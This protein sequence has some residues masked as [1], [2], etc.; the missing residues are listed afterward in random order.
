MKLRGALWALGGLLGFSS[1]C[2]AAHPV[3][4]HER[5]EREV[6]PMHG[7]LGSFHDAF[8]PVYHM[9]KGDERDA[10][11]CSNAPTFAD[12]AEHV[13]ADPRSGKDPAFDAAARSLA[14]RV[15]ELGAACSAHDDIAAKLEAVHDAF[16]K[17]LESA[18]E[19]DLGHH[20]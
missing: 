2:G 12:R 5:A 14:L 8:A 4:E 9:D 6:A 17:T 13:V 16:H 15:K 7:T 18:H 20:P 19:G 3:D 1:A 11:A 10:A